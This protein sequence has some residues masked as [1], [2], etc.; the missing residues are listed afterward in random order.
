MAGEQLTEEQVLQQAAYIE[1]Q[2]LDAYD[3]PEERDAA[4]R[5]M[6]DVTGVDAD[7]KLTTAQIEAAEKAAAEGDAPIKPADETKAGKETK[8]EDTKPTE[9]AKAVEDTKPVEETKPT[10][11]E[12]LT[13]RLDDQSRA[14]SAMQTKQQTEESATE[15][16]RL[17]SEK[18]QGAVTALKT[19]RDNSEKEVEEF[20]DSYG[21]EAAEKLKSQKDEVF[22]LRQEAITRDQNDEFN[23]LQAVQSEKSKTETE[24]MSDIQATPELHKWHQ[25]MLAATKGD[26]TKSADTFNY[27]IQ[28]DNLL[29]GHPQWKSKPQIERFAEVE[30]RV[31]ADLEIQPGSPN[32]QDK[33]QATT[34]EQ[35]KKAIQDQ[36]QNKDNLPDTLSSLA[37]GT[38]EGNKGLSM[39]S[40]DKMD[41]TDIAALGYTSEQLAE[42]ASANFS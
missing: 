3:T 4:R 20:R 24:T 40:L 15:F 11:V 34:K 39:E 36:A 10:E 32:L 9:A 5:M 27:A 41:M 25:D 1:E 33:E 42:F 2:I 19:E 14:I 8:P 28:V 38:S 23:R 17:A 13:K 26:T 6:Q 37:G 30:R 31:K 29:Q 21:D 18:V 16:R 22:Q 12:V 35:I 7:T